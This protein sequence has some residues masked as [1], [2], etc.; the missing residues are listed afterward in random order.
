MSCCEAK[1]QAPNPSNLRWRSHTCSSLCDI[2]KRIVMGHAQHDWPCKACSPSNTCRWSQCHH[3][4]N[5]THFEGGTPVVLSAKQYYAVCS[6][7]PHDGSAKVAMRALNAGG[8]NITTVANQSTLATGQLWRSF[9][10]IALHNLLHEASIM[11]QQ[12]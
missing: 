10:D 1:C 6:I 12:R 11:A 7:G 2:R 9:S 8:H 4:G 5:P 3:C